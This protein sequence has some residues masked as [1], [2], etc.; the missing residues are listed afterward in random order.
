MPNNTRGWARRRFDQI[1]GNYEV[2]LQYMLELY[3]IYNEPHPEIG[4]NIELLRDLTVECQ[5]LS[6]K[7]KEL[8]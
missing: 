1:N 5:K 2:A 3:Q 7:I 6:E 8:I 4:S